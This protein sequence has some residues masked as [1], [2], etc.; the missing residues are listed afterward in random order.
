MFLEPSFFLESNGTSKLLKRD[1]LFLVVK[2]GVLC[3]VALAMVDSRG[4][5]ERREEGTLASWF[6]GGLWSM[7]NLA[8]ETTWRTATFCLYSAS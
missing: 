5:E 6:R 7:M 1:R 3:M 2:G 8:R 4:R